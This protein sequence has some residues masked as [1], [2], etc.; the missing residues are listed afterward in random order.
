M[1][2]KIEH[3]NNIIIKVKINN[4]KKIVDYYIYIYY[5]IL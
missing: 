1:I 5:F 2:K 4:I 3:I